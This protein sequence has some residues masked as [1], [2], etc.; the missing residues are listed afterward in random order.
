ML[1]RLGRWGGKGVC[2]G[3]GALLALVGA[4]PLSPARA[5]TG[6]DVTVT[7][8]GPAR[9]GV[10][11]ALTYNVQVSG[12]GARTE[13]TTLTFRLPDQEDF[14]SVDGRSCS[15]TADRRG[16]VCAYGVRQ[17]GT[18]GQPDITVRIKDSVPVGTRITAD[19]TTGYR[20][21]GTAY[22]GG[23]ASVVTEAV[24]GG[25][26]C[27][28]VR[29]AALFPQS[30]TRTF[31]ALPTSAAER[32]RLQ[33]DLALADVQPTGFCLRANRPARVT[34]S[35]G[36]PGATV[37]LQVGTWALV[38]PYSR[39]GY[40]TYTASQA[41]PRSYRLTVGDNTISD[42]AGGILY[43]RHTANSPA[44]ASAVTVTLDDGPGVQP[45]PQYDR[46]STT[47]AQWQG[48]LGATTAAGPVELVGD[49]VVIAGMQESALRYAGESQD[50]LL[51]TYEKIL[52]AED[53]LCGL[54]GSSA[55]DTRSPL[56]FFAVE[57]PSRTNPN[58]T[59]YRIAMPSNRNGVLFSATEA[60]NDWGLFHEFGHQHQQ[61]WTWGE[62]QD[63]N[64]VVEVT[65]NIY[66][67]AADR[68]FAHTT[69][70]WADETTW[71]PGRDYLAQ[72]ARRFAT[73]PNKVQFDMF[74]QLDKAFGPT[75]YPQLHRRMR[76]DRPNLADT[77]Q[78]MR[79][80][81]VTAS[82]I[83]GVDLTDYF[84]DRWAVPL[85]RGTLAALAA[86][87][88]PKPA[89]D[90]ST[91]AAFTGRKDDRSEIVRFVNR[92]GAALNRSAL[93]LKDG[94]WARQPELR[95]PAGRTAVLR[96]TTRGGID[97]TT[98]YA[99][100]G[101]GQGGFTYRSPQVGRNNYAVST[102]QGVKVTVNDENQNSRTTP[103]GT[104]LDR[105][106]SDVLG[107]GD[108]PTVWV[109]FDRP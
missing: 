57:S 3:L 72:S 20:R 50:D 7:A 52:R 17:G 43:V 80:F 8:S 70:G 24:P 107:K 65:V 38:D 27:P 28:V 76:A 68:Q 1:A 108:D 55:R 96:V 25:L 90:P 58:A 88:L 31:P 106:D 29:D 49:H 89:T 97:G 18:F 67:M 81:T 12:S 5:Q 11:E 16:V 73:A 26:A 74:A 53:D 109:T 51:D 33:T 104:A 48:M 75:F 56:R 22:Q 64:N 71:A 66:S 99:L 69:D 2:T 85:D 4:A 13:D 14:V 42:P 34:V 6:N 45:I 98:A 23:T 21:G 41:P 95:I 54:D 105:Y 59:Y 93:D 39:T 84:A 92:T 103:P 79:W 77:D 9:A 91:V 36:S 30:R 60:A 63:T 94:T 102:T 40:G 32:D 47:N 10:G 82:Q 15:V 83:A 61:R 100:P 78:Q 86:L 35:G 44:A 101:P 87:G 46:Q 19:F 62:D 37:E